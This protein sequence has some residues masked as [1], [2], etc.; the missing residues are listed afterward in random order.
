MMFLVTRARFRVCRS[1]DPCPPGRSAPGSP[2]TTA[3]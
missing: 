2:A 1:G 3:V